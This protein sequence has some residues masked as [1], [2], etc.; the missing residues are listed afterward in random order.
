[1]NRIVLPAH[2]VCGRVPGSAVRRGDDPPCAVGVHG[3]AAAGHRAQVGGQGRQAQVPGAQG[4][5]S[6]T[7]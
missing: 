4:L 2:E 5:Y 1:M 6:H 7:G 3:A